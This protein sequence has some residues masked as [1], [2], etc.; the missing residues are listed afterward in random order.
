[1]SV[2]V[3]VEDEGDI[4]R[5]MQS[6]PA[7]IFQRVQQV[8]Q[9]GAFRLAEQARELAPVRTGHLMASIRPDIGDRAES[10]EAFEPVQVIA[11]TP[12]ASFVEFG[13]S[14]ME[15]QPFLGPAAEQIQPEIFEEI[16]MVLSELG[17][18]PG[19]EQE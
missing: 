2:E 1:M 19:M 4:I 10:E 8:L 7:E 6:L 11:D 15:A 12:Y 18:E 16:D 17:L 14:R 5:L 13:T 9:N 3:T